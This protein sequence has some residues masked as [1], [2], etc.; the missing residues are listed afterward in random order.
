MSRFLINF[1][2]YQLKTFVNKNMKHIKAFQREMREAK[3]LRDFHNDQTGS[4]IFTDQRSLHLDA[5]HGEVAV[6]RGPLPL[7]VH[8]AGVLVFINLI[9]E[10]RRIL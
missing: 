4:V 7:G 1:A 3:Y 8:L 6:E 9:L 2:S 5:L 10:R